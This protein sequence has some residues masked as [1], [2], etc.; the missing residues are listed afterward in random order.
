MPGFDYARMQATAS[1][2][3]SRF[4]QGA[5]TLTRT[6][7]GEPDP[8]TPWIPGEPTVTTYTLD[9]TVRGVAK[10]FIDGTTILATDLEVTAAA[11]GTDP[12]PGDTLAIDGQ[13]V[14]IIKQM[15]VPAAGT[16]VCWKWIVR[17]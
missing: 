16:L 1:R 4:A 7:P 3:L 11:L 5:V 15:R 12:G 8:E 2:L 13:T 9:A 10:E 14:T 6:I 17:G